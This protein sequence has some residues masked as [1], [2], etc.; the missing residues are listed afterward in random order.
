MVHFLGVYL[1]GSKY[2][3][4]QVALAPNNAVYRLTGCTPDCAYWI[5]LGCDFRGAV[6]TC[7]DSLFDDLDLT[8]ETCCS[9]LDQR[10]VSRK[11]HFVNMA[12]GIE[13]IERIENN[14][15]SFEPVNVELG[16]FDIGVV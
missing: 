7:S 4:Q 1:R 14:F 9:T 5:A 13:V 12:A 8:I 3:A 2:L 6:V 11:T 15:E 10:D 16:I